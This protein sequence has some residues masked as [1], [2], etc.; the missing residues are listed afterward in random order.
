MESKEVGVIAPLILAEVEIMGFPNRSMSSLQKGCE[1][2]RIPILESVPSKF[3]A[4][5]IPLG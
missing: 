4:K 2:I 1:V 5:P 3:E